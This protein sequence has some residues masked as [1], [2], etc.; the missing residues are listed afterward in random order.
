MSEDRFKPLKSAFAA[1]FMLI[2]GWFGGVD[3]HTPP[4]KVDTATTQA[5]PEQPEVDPAL[6]KGLEAKEKMNEVAREYNEGRMELSE[7][8]KKKLEKEAFLQLNEEIRRE[9]ERKARYYQVPDRRRRDTPETD[10]N[11]A[12]E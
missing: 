12:M 8:E 11:G 7:R 10:D 9:Q 4:P 5:V 3:P 2:S 6:H 1:V